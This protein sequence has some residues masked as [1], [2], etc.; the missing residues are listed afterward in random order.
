MRGIRRHL[1]FANVVSMIALF[2]AL[3]GGAYA[4]SRGEVKSRNI[5]KDAV[6]ARHIAFGVRSAP[7]LANFSQLKSGTDS[8]NYAPVGDSGPTD[9]LVHE[10][11]TPQTFFATGLRINL[12]GPLAT[13]T[14]EFIL[15]Y[16]TPNTGHV[17][18]NLRC[19][20][21]VGEQRCQSNA[22]PRIPR[23]A[24]IWFEAESTGTTE[25]DYAEVGWRAVLP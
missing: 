7:M 20:V 18:T 19:D 4:L 11:L 13:G 16:W 5:A 17:L 6:K 1:T 12:D 9:N 23:G 2:V 3:G 10:A 8:T 14:R 24:T 22:R 21:G 15:R 25:T